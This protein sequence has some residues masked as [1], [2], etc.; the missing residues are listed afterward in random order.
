MSKASKKSEEQGARPP[1]WVA[2][3]QA[4]FSATGSY[5]SA[6]VARILG[7]QKKS[8]EVTP[9]TDEVI[10]QQLLKR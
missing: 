7:D 1:S 2:D 10:S 3:A 9:K 4:Y 8:V 5:R 6:D